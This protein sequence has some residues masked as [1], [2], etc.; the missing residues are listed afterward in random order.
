[1][2]TET[3]VGLLMA[4]VAAGCGEARSSGG[5]EPQAATRVV[6]AQPVR[7]D[8]TRTLEIAA[9]LTPWEQAVLYAKASGYLREIRVD[10]GDRV[11]KGKLLAVLD[12]PEASLEIERY[13]AE[14]REALAAADKARAD[15]DL[16]DRTAARLE[17]IRAEEPGAVSEQ[18]L[19]EA[20]GRAASARA[21][22][23]RQEK[24]AAALQAAGRRERAMA[25][26]RRVVAP[27]DGVVTE[28]YVDPG[29]LIAAG[30]TGK[31]Q[32]IVKIVNP[33]RLRVI[34]DVS[35]T[36]VRLVKVGNRARLRVDAL[37]DAEFSG[38]VARRAEAVDPATRTMRIEIEIDNADGRLSP[39]MFGRLVLDLE[40]RRNVLTIEPSWM[41]LQKDRPYVMVADGGVAKKVFIET[42]ADDGVSIECV[43][44]LD[45]SA[46]IITTG[47]R[48][49]SDGDKVEVVTGAN[50]PETGDSP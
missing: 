13:A 22:V 12:I 30:T 1:M 21:S 2:R 48:Q 6:C 10:R 44:G 26:Y 16:A 15:L 31:A 28:R 36:E 41:V 24:R 32:P 49:L 50:T 17:N 8:V 29:A 18:Q 46:Q 43:S 23:V 19:D 42:G 33:I 35:E 45:E 4:M 20:R 3:I 47:V 9:S 37:P 27:F 34:A 40:T 38:T 39:G 25:G 14:S 7:R 11:D 5:G